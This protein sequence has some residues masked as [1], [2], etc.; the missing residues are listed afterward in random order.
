MREALD[1][2]AADVM[3]PLGLLERPLHLFAIRD[4]VT[5]NSGPAAVVGIEEAMDG[6]RLLADWQVLQ[7]LNAVVLPDGRLTPPMLL[8]RPAASSSA[9]KTDEWTVKFLSERLAELDLRYDVPEIRRL[10]T[11]RPTG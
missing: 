10:A 1:Y 7:L 8:I 6:P 2:S 4:R 3:V 9:S 11:L 5:S